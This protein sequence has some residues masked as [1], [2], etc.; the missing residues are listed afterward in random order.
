MAIFQRNLTSLLLEKA[1][2]DYLLTHKTSKHVLEI[3]CGDGNITRSIAADFRHNKY[4]ASDISREAIE[5][6]NKLCP[7]DLKEIIEFKTSDGFQH[8][9]ISEFD[10]ILCDISAINQKIAAISDW[11]VGIQH[12]TGD[13]GLESIRPIIE[14]VTRYLTPNG[15]FILPSISLSNTS[16]LHD[17]LSHNFKSAT[18]VESKD[19]P[20]PKELSQKIIELKIPN[21]G[22][23]WSTKNKFGIEIAN[24]GVL[25]C[26][27]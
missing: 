27:I 7:D 8:W 22:V 4:F 2:R 13:D 21:K 20:V 1:L 19:W 3:G 18:L 5:E 10:I 9:D 25:L 16:K 11:Y 14:N 12:E 26:E 17:L 15:I 24:T 6:A 23:D